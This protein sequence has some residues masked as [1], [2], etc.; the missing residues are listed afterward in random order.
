MLSQQSYLAQGN[1]SGIGHATALV[2]GAGLGAQPVNSGMA[3]LGGAVHA[4]PSMQQQN[5][6][7]SGLISNSGTN[8]NSMNTS[9]SQLNKSG[10]YEVPG[11]DSSQDAK[12][13]Q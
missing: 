13:Q 5:F 9:T 12:Q 1:P 3:S 2:G 7:G 4:A 11:I 10:N 6:I 8:N